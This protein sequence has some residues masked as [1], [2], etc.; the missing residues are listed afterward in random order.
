MPDHTDLALFT[1]RQTL[2]AVRAFLGHVLIVI[3]HDDAEDNVTSLIHAVD[4]ILI[5]VLVLRRNVRRSGHLS[6]AY[7]AIALP[8]LHCLQVSTGRGISAPLVQ[9]CRVAPNAA[10]P[11]R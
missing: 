7:D 4:D 11:S 9:E 10:E 8:R 5:E 3:L 1:F 2:L 6:S